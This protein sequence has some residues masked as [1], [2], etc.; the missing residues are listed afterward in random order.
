MDDYPI[1]SCDWDRE[2]GSLQWR[3]FVGNAKMRAVPDNL[4]IGHV[5]GSGLATFGG[6]ASGVV[7]VAGAVLIPCGTAVPSTRRLKTTTIELLNYYL[8]CSSDK[9]Y[10]KNPI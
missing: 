3:K 10:E 6:T 5:V 2:D 4:L 8:K 7:E 1:G 9:S